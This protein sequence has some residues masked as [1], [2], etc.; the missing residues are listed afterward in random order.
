MD[1]V[2]PAAFPARPGVPR[3]HAVSRWLGVR[4]RYPAQVGA[5]AITYYLAAQ[6][7][8]ALDFAGPVAAIVWLPV[9]VAISFLYL[10]GVGLWPGV[11]VGDLLVNDYSALPVG[12]AAGQ[13]FGNLLEVL[14][15]TLLMRRLIPRGA[16][17]A[18]VGSL[19]RMVL[20]IAAGATVSASIG[21]L[22]LHLGS[23]IGTGAVPDVWRTWWLGDFAGA[24]IV[25][26]V[27][28]AWYRPLP[29]N[30]P[31][32]R[33]I[34]GALMAVAVAG[35]SELA[36]RSH[37]PVAYLVFPMLT[38]AALRFGER[39]RPS[40][41]RSRS[42]PRCGT[43]PTTRARSPFARSPTAS[44]P[45][46]STSRWRRCPRS[47]SSRWSPSAR[48]SPAGWRRLARAWW[49]PP[50]PSDGGWGATSTTGLSSA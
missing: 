16:P 10:G 3:T 24:L 8:F 12:S 1:G 49:R 47:S 22:S 5:L 19:A 30:W 46:S 11:L 25:V 26:P 17:L 15:A 18:S 2:K 40:P 21:A 45:P 48:R 41:S 29:R 35:A 14:V 6:V 38:W 39:G 42:A 7:G 33:A 43:P 9:G 31:R 13:T 4:G 23:V 44:S 34:E 28:L 37:E 50:R 32:G 36:F 27:A 20:A